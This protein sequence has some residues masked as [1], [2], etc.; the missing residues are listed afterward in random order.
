MK[1]HFMKEKVKLISSEDRE[2]TII[3]STDVDKNNTKKFKEVREESYY[4]WLKGKRLDVRRKGRLISIDNSKTH[5][6]RLQRDENFHINIA[7]SMFSFSMNIFDLLSD[8]RFDHVIF[9]RVQEDFNTNALYRHYTRIFLVAAELLDD[10][11]ALCMIIKKP[12]QVQ[13]ILSPTGTEF[14]KIMTFINKIV[15]HKDHHF[16]AVNNH[17]PLYFEDSDDI[18]NFSNPISINNCSVNNPDGLIIPRLSYLINTLI[19]GYDK[20]EEI[21]QDDICFKEL[22]KSRFSE[23]ENYKLEIGF[24]IQSDSPI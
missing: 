18:N 1:K 6:C 11:R 2:F 3:D 4:L 21:Y 8:S 9:S 5:E 23:K 14:S 15:K 20:I 24:T 17:L 7:C 13:K 19:Y 12:N 16:H 10:L 22:L